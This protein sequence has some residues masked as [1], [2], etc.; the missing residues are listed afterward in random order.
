MHQQRSRV[1]L[2]GS[3]LAIGG[4]VAALAGVALGVAA[5]APWRT[6]GMVRIDDVVVSAVAAL[7]ALVCTWLALSCALGAVCVVGRL[8]GRGWHGGEA[9]VRRWAPDIVR[10][11][12][13]A[14][15]GGGIALGLAA[16]GASAAPD[17]PS[18]PPATVSTTAFVETPTA[19]APPLAWTVTTPDP[20]RSDDA[21]AGAGDGDGGGDGHRGGDGG[22]DGDGRGGGDGE[23]GVRRERT[24][25]G[26][27]TPTRDTTRHAQG[28]ATD[29]TSP[30][31]TRGSGDAAAPRTVVVRAGDSLWTIAAAALGP[32]A[33]AAEVAEAWPAWYEEN[34][35]VIG[36]DPDLVQVGQV[37]VTPQAAR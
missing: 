5:V 33:S 7:G 13:A 29:R 34:R 36:A 21:G 25:D 9:A 1:G 12:V 15:I 37:L 35:D 19:D 30:D 14:T 16:T 8:V 20:S 27:R 17:T 23:G 32:A 11:A 18:M 28:P 22:G 24:H 3:A 2:A 6:S 26:E 4:A 31:G 10:R